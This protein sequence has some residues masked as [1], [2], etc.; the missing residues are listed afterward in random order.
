MKNGV[1]RCWWTRILQR[2]TGD[3]RRNLTKLKQH[4]V[5]ADTDQ[6]SNKR[7]PI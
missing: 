2:R 6:I 4:W 5:E 1:E 3:R 7:V